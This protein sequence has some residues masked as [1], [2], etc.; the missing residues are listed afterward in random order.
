MADLLV[1]SRPARSLQND[2]GF[3]GKA[4]GIRECGLNATENE[5][6]AS[7]LEPPLPKRKGTK[8]LFKAPDCEMREYQ[9]E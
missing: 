8:P 6:L 4:S 1:L 9:G 5:Q 2:A 7:T 3:S